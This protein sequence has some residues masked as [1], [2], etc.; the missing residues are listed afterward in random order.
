MHTST[1]GFMVDLDATAHDIKLTQHVDGLTDGQ[2]YSLTFEAGAPLPDTAH[3][4]VWFGGEKI[5]DIDPT[6]GSMKSYTF[7]VIGGSGNGNDVLEFRETGTPD[8][9]GTYLANVK[10]NNAIVIDETPG[11]DGDSNDTTDVAVS[12]LFSGVINVGHDADM[13][14]PQFAT[15]KSPIVNVVA[16][17]GTDGPHGANAAAGTHYVLTTTPTPGGVDSGLTTTEGAHI[18]LFSEN[19]D[20]IIVGRYDSNGDNQITAADNAAFA[21]TVDPATGVVSIAQYVSLHHPDTSSPDEG[22]YLNNGTLSVQV[23]VTDGDGDTASQ[24]V[25][26]SGMIR[27]EDD[28]PT[29]TALADAISVNEGNLPSDRKSCAGISGWCRSV[30]YRLPPYQLGRR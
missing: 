12:N 6:V 16:D 21:F 26:V 5:A 8:N 4:E 20:T 27:F 22:I 30:G 28:G 3:L 1:G 13:A 11:V 7:E 15:G 18:F 23:T 29:V 17:F 14:S 25:D 19:N 9:Q 10:I 2:N 24:S